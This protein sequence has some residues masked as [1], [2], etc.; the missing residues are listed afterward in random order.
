[1]HRCRSCYTHFSWRRSRRLKTLKLSDGS[2]AKVRNIASAIVLTCCTVG[3]FD[4]NPITHA[5]QSAKRKKQPEVLTAEEL[6]S[7]LT[8]LSGVN[9][10]M[11]FVAVATGLRVSE[12]L[13]LSWLCDFEAGEIR[14]SRGMVRQR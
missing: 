4:R 8:G 12:L 13:A 10:V 9:R 7:L 3:V 11:V 14:L 2:K 5:R 6:K 1:M